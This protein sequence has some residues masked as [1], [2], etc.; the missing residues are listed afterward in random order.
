MENRGPFK[1]FTI[2]DE[3]FYGMGGDNGGAISGAFIMIK[4]FRI[5]VMVSSWPS[6]PFVTFQFHVLGDHCI[7]R[8]ASAEGRNG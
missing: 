3:T 4:L 7:R 5:L 8:C 2:L 6:H 1:D